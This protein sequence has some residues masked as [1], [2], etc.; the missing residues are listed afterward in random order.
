MRV[1]GGSKA[2]NEAQAGH[3]GGDTNQLSGDTNQP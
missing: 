2:R 3:A 1:V